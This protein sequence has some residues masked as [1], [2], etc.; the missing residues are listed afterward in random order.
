MKLT[1]AERFV[2]NKGKINCTKSL[3]PPYSIIQFRK[4][5][6]ICFRD[7]G[8]GRQLKENYLLVQMSCVI[9]RNTDVFLFLRTRQKERPPNQ[10][11]DIMS[12]LK[13]TALRGVC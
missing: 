11:P 7:K 1:Q 12:F 2:K 6:Y 5:N 9:L 10:L 4:I 8:I 13:V 3:Y